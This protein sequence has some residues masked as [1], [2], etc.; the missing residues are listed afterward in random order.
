MEV[1]RQWSC[2]PGWTVKRE[3]SRLFAHSS[4]NLL[5][6]ETGQQDIGGMEQMTME[7]AIRLSATLNEPGRVMQGAT[8]PGGRSENHWLVS[9]PTRLYTS[10]TTYR[11]YIGDTMQV[12]EFIV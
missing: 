10:P 3:L 11:A 1:A 2:V 5:S 6:N 7:E 4:P 9:T 8:P 12:G